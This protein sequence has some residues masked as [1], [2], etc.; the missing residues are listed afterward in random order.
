MV[1]TML[2][3]RVQ[4]QKTPF[5]VAPQCDSELPLG[6][7]ATSYT[8]SGDGRHSPLV[9]QAVFIVFNKDYDFQ[10]SFIVQAP[11]FKYRLFYVC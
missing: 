1:G 10:N 7:T 11:K 9:Y 4:A 8:S 3:L 5:L 2:I 6:T